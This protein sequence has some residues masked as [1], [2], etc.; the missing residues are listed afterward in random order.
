MK[1]GKIR[2]E[3]SIS[4]TKPDIQFKE[5]V[6]IPPFD[7]LTIKV[8][9]FRVPDED[10]KHFAIKMTFYDQLLLTAI[11]KSIGSREIIKEQKILASGDMNYDPSDYEKMCLFADCPLVVNAQPLKSG[12]TN[13]SG[14]SG[15]KLFLNKSSSIVT[16]CQN[17]SCCNIDILP[18]FLYRDKMCITKRMEPMIEPSI[19]HQKSWDNLPLLTIELSVMRNPLNTHHHKLLKEANYMKLTLIAS[20]NMIVPYNDEYV[21][22]AASKMPLHNET[23][24]GLVT[25]NQGYRIPKKYRCMSFY[26]KW[27][28]LR[29][30]DNIFTKGDEKIHFNIEDLQNYHDIDVNRYV[31]NRTDPYT[32]VWGSFHRTLMLKDSN[33]WLWRH[34]RQYK[35]PLEVHMY[36]EQDGYSFMAFLDLFQ[37]LYPGETTIRL[38]APLQWINSQAMM[39][40]C[41]CDL[42]L[43]SNKKGPSTPGSTQ[44][45]IK[46]TGDSTQAS[47][48][49]DV[50]YIARPT[51]SNENSAFVIVEVKLDKPLKKA[52]I[53]PQ[54]TNAEIEEMLKEMERGANKRECTGRGQ[55]DRD[56]HATV[57]SAVN[58]LRKVPHYGMTEF[59]NFNRQFSKTRTRVE[60]T[61]SCWQDAAV[62]V[63]NNFV[64]QDFLS[65]DELYEEMLMMAHACLMKTTCD[66]LVG[67]DNPHEL[68]P[69]LRAARHARYLQDIPHA[70]ELY[71]QLVV[72]RPRD[73]DCW[74][75]LGT[76]LLDVD[77]DWANV[78]I[79]KS[80]ELNPRH[81]L[82]LLSKGC[83]VFEKDPEAAEIFF[84]ALLSLHP[85]WST[86]WIVANAYY[87]ERELFNLADEIMM[88][89]KKNQ[90]K[91]YVDILGYPRSW[92]NELGDW[93]D[94]TPL[95]PGM[96]PY[97]HA[98][99]LL[100]R[101]RAITLAE[102]CVARALS[103]AGESAAYFHLVA[104]CCRLRGHID[105]ALCHIRQGIQKFG[106]ISYMRSLEAECLHK[107]K[108]YDGANACFEKA[109]TCVSAYSILLA[110]PNCDPQRARSVL[111]DLI[112]REPNAYA[113]MALAD[114]WMKRATTGEGG[115]ADTTDGQKSAKTCAAACAVQALKL[116][117]RA[118]RAWALLAKL[119]T[120]SARRQHCRDMAIA[121]G[122]QWTDECREMGYHSQQSLCYK[123]STS[124][125]ECQCKL[126]SHL[127]F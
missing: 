61:T 2:S 19:L 45:P 12:E 25:F 67:I 108:D 85:F 35:W 117:R 121:C 94:Y 15:D 8:I 93:W 91:G 36:G 55:L 96:C 42:L 57:R 41:G 50:G 110:I 14:E 84:V 70:T 92:N 98:A 6:Y 125:Q 10:P 66:V 22:S 68:D 5:E 102:V 34:L 23:N 78:C 95:L 30:S 27:E 32:T 105:E 111:V 87:S 1:K 123:V 60:L 17:I 13:L 33:T 106:E 58:S 40:N 79:S 107:N 80:I 81:P 43:R 18:I 90:T 122:Y 112:R 63:N 120:P 76:C 49:T 48:N 103:E 75:E 37:L 20:Y 82:T 88:Y 62:Y 97:Y 119:V 53:P 46:N 44:K 9:S 115:D 38:V 52:V 99:D 86:G 118:G 59:C 29:L 54:I 28:S 74:R 47:T 4:I 65:S 31:H 39:E 116:D 69:V 73:A 56:W 64:V 71:L 113:W 127:I 83:I 104:L 124:L 16:S 126:C 109:G 51:G 101:L 26:P 114:D 7:V 72:Q 21:Y 100:L 3:A 89:F 24:C 77:R 11:I